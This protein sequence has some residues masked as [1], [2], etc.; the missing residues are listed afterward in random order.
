[1]EKRSE[2]S[3][4]EPLVFSRTAEGIKVYSARDP[5]KSYLVSGSPEAPRCTCPDFQSHGSDPQ[6]RCKH[7][8]L[9]SS[10]LYK[11][12]ALAFSSTL[13]S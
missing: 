6:W 13:W 4:I 8:L 1:M 12:W 7:I 2:R 3:E 10:Q 11:W 9:A 5:K